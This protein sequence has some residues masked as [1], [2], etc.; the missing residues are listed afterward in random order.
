MALN[1]PMP[2]LP[3]AGLNQAISTGGNL[4]HQMINPVIQRENMQR[5]WKEHLG[6]L[7]VSQAAS[8]R[9]AQMMPLQMQALRDAHARAEMETNPAKKLAYMQAILKGVHEMNNGAQQAPVPNQPMGQPPAQQGGMPPMN[10]TGMLNQE[11]MQQQASAPVEPVAPVA[12]ME[13]PLPGAENGQPNASVFT[14]EQEMAMGM[15]GIKMPKIIENPAAKRQA[16]LESKMKLAKYE[17]QMNQEDLRVK[18]DLANEKTR[19]KTMQA[20]K[21]DIPHL[22]EALSALTKMKELAEADVENG[23][24]NKES[25]FGHRKPWFFGQKKFEESTHNPA[26]GEWQALGIGPITEIEKKLSSKGNIVALNAAMANKPNFYEQK[27]PALAKLNTQIGIIEN[28]IKKNKKIAGIETNPFEHM[29]DEELHKIA[30]G[31]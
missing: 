20:A 18:K 23:V 24:G 29:S 2:Q 14:P 4:F 6:N 19:E 9:A 12:G 11:A 16:D 31:G 8:G 1:I 21:E 25:L 3:L 17:H 28:Q 22:E 30:G 10:G 27:E 5:Q 7:A 15:A 26:V 13:A